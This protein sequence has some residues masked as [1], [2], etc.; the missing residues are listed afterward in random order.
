MDDIRQQATGGG[1]GNGDEPSSINKSTIHNAETYQRSYNHLINEQADD[2]I[3]HKTF[4]SKAKSNE[5]DQIDNKDDIVDDNDDQRKKTGLIYYDDCIEHYCLWD[6][7]YEEN[8]RR[9]LRTMER[10]FEQGLLDE[11]LR[12]K[13]RKANENEIQLVHSSEYIR[14]IE[15]ICSLMDPEQLEQESS[16][17][18]AVYFTPSSYDCALYASGSVLEL[19]DSLMSGRI[20][21]GMAIVR[22]P[23]HHAMNSEACG[24]CIFNNVAI[25]ARYCQEKYHL[26]RILIIDWDVHHGQATQQTF[27]KDPNVFYVSIHRYEQGSFWP[28]LIES[29]YNFCG[30]SSGRGFN[31]NIPL[32]QT[33]LTDTDYL[34]IW[35]NLLLPVFY[36]FDPELI[37]VSAG[38][39]SAI[40]CPEGEM[41][42]T[43]AVYSH[44]THYLMGLADGKLG[45]ILEGGYCIESLAD[46]VVCTV[47]TLIGQPPIPLN[48]KYPINQ[49]VIESILNVITVHQSNWSSLC[50]QKTFDRH[51]PHIDDIEEQAIRKRHYPTLEYCGLVD[52]LDKRPETYPTRDCYPKHSEE[53]GK[54]LQKIIEILRQNIQ[55][56]TIH[57]DQNR[58]TC[59]I[60][61]SDQSNRH[62]AP[63]THPERPNR[64]RYL[65]RLL[66]TEK[67]LDKCF[68]L[69][70]NDNNRLVTDQELTSCH[71]MDAIEKISRT[72]Q[73][74]Y[75]ELREYEQQF[76]SIY[77]TQ[78]SFLVAKSSIGSLLKVV[79][80]VLRNECLN[81]FACIRPPGHHAKR[82]EP[83]GFCLFN[84]IAIAAR[85]ALEKYRLRRI[86]IVDWDIH[87]GDGTQDIVA[88]DERILF[89][90]LHR[91]DNG[92]FYPENIQASNYRTGKRNII[93]IPWSNGQMGD[94][95]YLTAF[96][97]IVMPVAYNFN[98][99]LVLVSSGFDAAENDPIGDYHLTPAV[100]GHMTHLLCSLAN[101]KIILSLEGGYH[102]RS[103]ANSALE[104]IR[105]LLGETPKS[106]SS[107]SSKSTTT[108]LINNDDDDNNNNNGDDQ[109]QKQWKL[110]TNAIDTIRN[111]IDYHS[112]YWPCF[113]FNV[114]LAKN[115]ID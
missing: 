40:G 2:D 83:A 71:S 77:F 13:P 90:S 26:K 68:V 29:N 84:Q 112:D 25:A 67:I 114:D 16:K 4:E 108:T 79:D 66:K 33:G 22:P 35:H 49:S 57:Y 19:C 73:M 30:E 63:Q 8:P 18:D 17:F 75:K 24:Y 23:G 80:C 107:S 7:N 87:H 27:Y 53:D 74:D 47:Q 3:F 100:Y 103:I 61:S 55:E 48:M 89:I 62:S 105:V 101:G 50:I 102:L 52:L 96:F 1:G 72:K 106:L 70:N 113:V 36:E 86:L 15:Q 41:L 6:D 21:N 92:D 43:P 45:I 110:D 12:L 51:D 93:N 109:N 111:V 38:Y 11:C 59:L 60:R 65:W 76:D 82:S 14:R 78:D 32:N 99:E 34:S 115:T 69:N 54:K 58:R 31:M 20:R 88:D 81:G 95:E 104:C 28:E 56:K 42:L 9:Y 98:P 97:N 64:I 85:Y 37:L 5:S 10:L 94:R 39:D 91:Y 46:S 44:F